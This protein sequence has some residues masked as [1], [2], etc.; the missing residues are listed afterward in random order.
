MF[1]KLLDQISKILKS[2]KET[3]QETNHAVF[4]LFIMFFYP[5]SP[6]FR[7]V[8]FFSYLLC[9]FFLV[10]C[11]IQHSKPSFLILAVESLRFDSFSCQKVLNRNAK[12]FHLQNFCREALWFTHAF[13][14][15]TMSQA[16]LASIL[17]GKYPHEHRVWHNGSSFLP[18]ENTTV[19]EQA[20]KEGYK[21]SL[22]SGGPPIWRKSG[23]SQGFEIFDDYIKID[24]QNFYRP[25]YK[26]SKL[27]LKWLKKS[28]RKRSFFSLIYVNDLQFSDTPTLTDLGETRR[29]NYESQVEEILESMNRLFGALKKQ[30]KWHNT[31]IVLVGL[32]GE[33][34]A[35]RPQELSPYN[36]HS[37]NTQVALYIRTPL[38]KNNKKEWKQKKINKNVSLVDVGLTLY[39]FLDKK[40]PIVTSRKKSL[41]ALSLKPTLNL[42]KESHHLKNSN[43]L[44]LIESAWPQWRK[45]G[46]TRFSIRKGAHLFLFDQPIKIYDTLADRFENIPLSKEDLQNSSVYEDY[47]KAL[48]FMK[49]MGFII[50]WPALESSLVQKLKVGKEL[51]RDQNWNLSIIKDQLKKL[52][53]KLPDD[54]QIQNW[55]AYQAIKQKEWQELKTLGVLN[56]N[57]FWIF[58]A[59]T[60]LNTKNSAESS[61]LL[62]KKE[63]ASLKNLKN[64]SCTKYFFLSSNQQSLSHLSK[65]SFVHLLRDCEDQLFV[66][67]LSWIYEKDRRKKNLKK[68]KFL[69]HYVQYKT[70][71]KIFQIHQTQLLSWDVKRE[72][73]D[74]PALTDLYFSLPSLKRTLYRIQ[75]REKEI[76]PLPFP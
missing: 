65:L 21:T 42:R 37:E 68:E 1:L 43:S 17:T 59:N 73:S 39:D 31:Y 20:L 60:Y 14:P 67:L 71:Q 16:A 5:L 30:K 44:I 3:N 66:K 51:W 38:K 23:F 50:E 18:E 10:S 76:S 62:F 36:L 53:K 63:K 49:G 69:R 13:T 26:S 61:N 41:Q 7:P 15:S 29:K 47:K 4:Y 22:F 74:R 32:N 55:S 19:S 72:F 2:K 6:F 64:K 34:K 25:L 56:H 40:L 58:L 28:V 12:W 52:R 35:F 9:L 33:Q 75:L 8:F 57:P 48:N 54:P 70:D 45:F 11:S 27:F 24:F 46:N